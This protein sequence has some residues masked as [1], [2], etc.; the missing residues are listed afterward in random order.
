M[1][2]SHVTTGATV[3]LVG[4]TAA[5]DA[6]IA[7]ELTALGYVPQRL[8]GA[9]RYATAVAVARIGLGS[10][11]QIFVTTGNDFADGLTAGVVAA[12]LNGAVLLT[13]AD[14]VPPDSTSCGHH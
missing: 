10:P 3:Y 12:R 7:T 11:T 13:N 9:N 14:Q 4:G 8:A 6:S 1:L 5:L 2:Q